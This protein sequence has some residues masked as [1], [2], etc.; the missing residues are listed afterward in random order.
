MLDNENNL[1]LKSGVSLI[2]V[3]LFML[4]AT[5]AATATY[6]LLTSGGFSSASRMRQQEAYQSALAGIENT[7]MWMTFHANDVGALVKA[8]I[9]GGE[10]PINLDAR[11][12]RWQ[13]A[14]QDY[15]VWLTGVNTENSTYKLK[16]L[17]SGV[18]QIVKNANTEDTLAR[19][20][21]VAIF[22]V[23]GLYQVKLLVE[24]KEEI[25][26]TAPFKYN[27]F[28]GSTQSQGHMKAYS[29]MINGD[30][31]GA[32]PVYTEENL[33]VTGDVHMTGNSVGAGGTACIGGNISADNGV[34]GN[35][36]Y[37]GGNALKGFTFPS[38]SEAAGVSRADLTGNV[39]IEG[40]LAPPDPGDQVFQGNL[41]LNGVWTTNLGAHE[42]KVKGN[43]CLGP[44]AQVIID[45]KNA[46]RKFIVGKN[47][48]AKD[49]TTP[50]VYPIWVK[51]GE[52]NEAEYDHI[53]L[54]DSANSTIYLR[55]VHS[56][57]EY[58]TLVNDRTFIEK[59]TYYRGSADN[60]MFGPQ[61]K[62]DNKTTRV[63]KELP[64]HLKN[65]TDAYYLY[66]YDGPGQDV[67]FIV[68]TSS[69]WGTGTTYYA[70]YYVENQPFYSTGGGTPGMF[71]YVAA[72]NHL[73]NMNGNKPVGSPYCKAMADKWRPECGVTP[74]FKS[75]G[76]I[77]RNVPAEENKG[78][79]CAESVK[80][81]CDMIWRK[82]PGEGCP[83]EGTSTVNNWG[84]G[85]KAD[86][87]V[88]DILVTAYQKFEKYANFGCRDV[89]HWG[90]TM[91][92]RLNRC[93]RDNTSSAQ[94]AKDSLYNGYQVVKV[95]RNWMS[96]PNTPLKGKFIIIVTEPMGQQNLPP[97]TSDSYVFLYLAEGTGHGGGNT[98][99]LQPAV[100]NGTYNYFI[101]TPKDIDGLMFNNAVFSG[102]IY[103]KA[104]NCAKVGDI[105]TRRMDF[106]EDLMNDLTANGVVCA[107]SIGEDACGSAGVTSSSSGG[108]SSAS[109]ESGSSYAAS[110]YDSFYISMAPQLGVRLESQS[111]SKEALPEAGEG[112]ETVLSPSFI[113][114]PRII[115][116]PS[117]PF[118][119]LTDYY[120]VQALNGSALKK[121]DVTVTCTGPGSLPATGKLYTAPTK[122][123]KGLYTCTAKASN[124]PDIPFWVSIGENSARE[125]KIISFKD[126]SQEMGSNEQ[127]DVLLNV[128]ALAQELKVSVYCPDPDNSAWSY[129]SL[130]TNVTRT[131]TTCEIT[132]PASDDVTTPT[133]ATIKT[134][135]ALEGTMVFQLFPGEGYIPGSPQATELFIRSIAQL[136]R[137]DVISSDI[138]DFCKD[139]SSICPDGYA[140]Y[141]PD[142]DV[143][144]VWVQP[145]GTFINKVANESWAIMVGNQ[146]PVTLEEVSGS[147]CVVIIPTENNSIATVQANHPPYSLRA[148]AKAVSSTFTVGFSG[149]VGGNGRD[150]MINV[151]TSRGTES[152]LVKTCKYSEATTGSETSAKKCTVSI[153]KGENVT[154]VLDDTDAQ[155][156]SFWRC[157]GS[158][159]PTTDATITSKTYNSFTLSDNETELI[160]VFGEKDKHC[161]FDEF[162][163]DSVGCDATDTQ[164]EYCIDKCSE[165]DATSVCSAADDATGTFKKAKWHLISGILSQIITGPSGE[166]HIEKSVIKKKKQTAREPVV[167]MSTVNA[168]IVG[169]LKALI[170]VPRVNSS[171][172]KSAVNIKKSGF[173]LR[174]NNFGNDYFMLNLYE[175]TN[176]V[177]EAQLTRGET[178]LSA[179]L[180][181]DDGYST[182]RVSNS[183]M[184]MV[185]AEITALDTLKVRANVGDF[186]GGSPIEYECVFALA[187]F[188]NTLADVAHE[189]VGFSL[190]DPNFKIYGI[191][192]KSGTYN[193]ECHDTYP[194]VKCSFAAVATD[195]V[196]KT[197]VDVKPWVGHSGWFD[198]KGCSPLYYY[199]NGNDACLGGTCDVY[200]FDESGIGAHGYTVVDGETKTEVKTA[201]AWLGNCLYNVS[202]ESVV[203]WGVT[204]DNQRAHCGAFWTGRFSECAAH[205]DLFSGTKTLSY[206]LEETIVFEKTQNLRAA[207]L[208]ITLENPEN[209]EVEIWLVSESENWGESDH[210]SHSVKMT[211]NTGTFDVMQE[212]A[213]GSSGFDPENVKQI[214]LK[215]HGMTS[216]TVKS[217]TSSCANAIGITSCRANFDGDKW[218]VT[219]Q[220]TNKTLVTK[221]QVVATVENGSYG[222]NITKNATGDDGIAWNGDVALISIPDENIYTQH[223]GKHYVFNAT[224]TGSSDEQTATKQCSVSPDPI[225]KIGVSC[226]VV[227]SI[228]SGARFPTFNIDFNGCPGAGCAYEVY[229]DGTK[230]VNERVEKTSARH[231]ADQNEVC[232][233]T[234]GCEHTYKVKSTT[235]P[236][237][238]NECSA[239]FKVL[240]KEEE[241]PP[242]VICGISTS[243]NSFSTDPVFTGNSL[244]F[245]A[246][247]EK[248]EDKTYSVTLKKGDEQVGTATL[249][250]W[251]NRT[252]VKS[253]G[254]A[255]PVGTHTYSLYVGND[256]VCDASVT[257]NDASGA[258]TIGGNLYTGQQL[259]MT[260]SGVNANTQFTWTLKKD[261]QTVGSRTIDCGTANCWNNTMNAPGTAGTYSYTVTKG[262]KE[263]CNGSVEIAPILTCSV[264]PTEVGRGVNYTFTANAAVNCWNCTFTD[265]AGSTENNLGINASWT[266]TKAAGNSIGDK[267]LSFNCNSCNNNA[268]ASCSVPLKVIKTKPTFSCADN[269]KA[270]VNKD[271]NVKIRLKDITNCDDDDK[272]DF[273]ISGTGSDASTY[274]GCTNTNCSL[275]AI[276]NKTTTNG[277]TETYAVTLTNS[278]GSTTEN[279]SVEFIAGPTC[280]VVTWTPSGT[281]DNTGGGSWSPSL[282]WTGECFDI[283]TSGYVCSG[284]IQIKAEN[285]KGETLN[286]NTSTVSLRSSDG[287]YEG[288]NPAAGTTIHIDANK[289]CTISNFYL[290]GCAN[291]K[292]AIS[293]AALST[294]KTKGS[295]VVLKPS[296]T[297]CNN[298]TK[299]SYTI[300]SGGTTEVEHSDKNWTSGSDMDALD[301]VNTEGSKNYKLTVANEYDESECTFT[302][303]Y[304]G[305]SSNPSITVTKNTDFRV[306]TTDAVTINI[307]GSETPGN[308]KIG[309]RYRGSGQANMSFTIGSSN[310]NTQLDYV[311]M[312]LNASYCQG[313]STTTLKVSHQPADCK[314]EWW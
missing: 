121:N 276:T 90:S 194:T 166:I 299:C 94:R 49:S 72:G 84:R 197:G 267:T 100:D 75:N 13:R 113:V 168:G 239:T 300:T 6:K 125:T 128:P 138:A 153:F 226:S 29:L 155:D 202:E 14:K 314:M 310:S 44:K 298:T 293:C 158:S 16:I 92:D 225:G 55:S 152:R 308:C 220:V 81:H 165:N 53:I 86:Y 167:V 262:A 93:Y 3:L 34:F 203:A 175:N 68:N 185:T 201:K 126:Q 69:G 145:T 140:S 170:N 164:M 37:V 135:N 292:P 257:V 74:W 238:F 161:F 143:A 279:C 302:I 160:A 20:D 275:P 11:V 307:S 306:S 274:T 313:G 7:R 286:W 291:R 83:H 270:T 309:C 217:I 139:H 215:N 50:Y 58:E 87:K 97:T 66:Y 240:R 260:V 134:T 108:T 131:G 268:N 76:T 60:G 147:G 51:N 48:W 173:M 258:C 79:E 212:F 154:V 249:Q 122:L 36:F 156:F 157:T 39:Y 21:E 210:E 132:L 236:E 85:G 117:D 101:Y 250:N 264:T 234:A 116:L 133:L 114:L 208:H 107:A 59:N 223:Q 57:A 32:N 193:S 195:G 33:I 146:A 82:T 26:A 137:S 246:Y 218:N 247:N 244:Y 19:W 206:G 266:K 271:N 110:G 38:A 102:S 109:A 42:S 297:N 24:E 196:I 41:S 30:L 1:R 43:L 61:A 233:V 52:N 287:Y 88:D 144:G 95:K 198:S 187:D 163:R 255:L 77:S 207:T 304:T 284:N 129:V 219:A 261:G 104:A 91:S 106:N 98:Y 169:T 71:G 31:F 281:P 162:K 242:T 2:T 111:K 192:W 174:A 272:C 254:D 64:P 115:Y 176:G 118:G 130:G 252:N 28:G 35:D 9:D 65:K 190:A 99:T 172:D 253:L 40:N 241:V 269:L 188:N 103:A 204:A 182:A 8:F 73:L 311:E 191:G 232:N 179:T 27:Y 123:T 221:E 211:G 180:T 245:V 295:S 213:S 256:K 289:S 285:C 305:S 151:Y 70:N 263:L 237:L 251:S 112:K 296:V 214:V 243:P 273:S 227:G 216:V 200:N 209:N 141:W 259:S 301:V 119:S 265:D 224:I 89:T 159:C 230:F 231:S 127:K 280:K 12:R 124:H 62:W 312:N 222:F 23:D 96:N 183:K 56:R 150:P 78:F 205:Q 283:S 181:K 199:Y 189:Y 18:S 120:N 282:N 142:C 136:N 149:D 80:A 186:Y 288:S 15:H 277:N 45:K 17:S 67:D 22:N 229:I 171:Y 46:S 294:S 54:G 303:N 63:Y 177:L 10:K 5:I 235:T 178:S 290:T 278:T 4:V 105:K 47:V 248:S 228:A 148:S 184:V 25:V